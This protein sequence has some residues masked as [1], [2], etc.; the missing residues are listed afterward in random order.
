MGW[1]IESANC[2]ASP[3]LS[4]GVVWRVQ[5]TAAA[6]DLSR[7]TGVGGVCLLA[8]WEVLNPVLGTLGVQDPT[9]VL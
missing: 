9:L 4:R 2:E 8:P 1:K 3:H 7:G 6:P 5:T